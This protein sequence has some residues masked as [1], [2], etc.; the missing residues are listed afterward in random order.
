MKNRWERE[1]GNNHKD[2]I[3]L[4][5]KMSGM[6]GKVWGTTNDAFTLIQPMRHSL[7]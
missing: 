3:G 1:V 6:V 7:N 5:G 2:W 4:K